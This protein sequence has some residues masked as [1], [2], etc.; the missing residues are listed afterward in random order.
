MPLT[1]ILVDFENVQPNAVDVGLV[2][3]DSVRL[4]I[5]RGPG[6]MKYAADL[7]EA[8]QPLGANLTFIRCA[9]AGRNA[10]DMH[11]AFYLGE[12]I[13]AQAGAAGSQAAVRFVVVSRDTDFDPLLLHV[14]SLGYEAQ[15]VATIRAALGA[16]A[17]PPAG[18]SAAAKKTPAKDVV[19]KK[20][21][22]KKAPA[23]KAT[24]ATK[25]AAPAKPVA[26]RKAAAKSPARKPVEAPREIVLASLRSLGER[27]PTRRKALEHHIESHLGRK[28]EMDAVRALVADMERE[29]WLKI[30]DNK[31]DYA[32]PKSRK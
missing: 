9:K 16:N 5:F 27:R 28:V 31:V 19:A 29:G 17:A 18:R 2:R 30:I 32:L 3:G 24:A 11:I 12:L 13:A 25:A 8:W 20:A 6:Q 7:A 1:Y 14:R 4:A 10:V 23:A 22:V 21:A 26:A 15:R